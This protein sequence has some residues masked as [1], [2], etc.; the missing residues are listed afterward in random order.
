M[1]LKGS[2]HHDFRHAIDCF[3]D[4]VLPPGR[5]GGA[6]LTVYHGGKKVVDV[7]G[8]SVNRS[9]TPWQEDTL[10]C[11]FSTTKG[12]AS[13]LLHII[14]DKSDASYDDP[15]I[16]Y[17]PEYGQNNKAETT[18]RQAL[19]MEAGIHDIDNHGF[20]VDS[21]LH[22]PTALEKTAAATPRFVPGSDNAY[23]AINYGFL[24]GGIIEGITGKT[25]QT[26]LQE[27]LVDP[28][29]LKGLFIGV[30]EQE[31]AR[32]A[33]LLTACEE[34]GKVA[35]M[36]KFLPKW[37]Q[38]I[39]DLIVKLLHLSGRDT[40]HFKDAFA[41]DMIKT[42]ESDGEQKVDFNAEELRGACI[43]GANGVFTARS[44][45][46]VYAM[47]ANKGEWGGKRY[48]SENTVAEMGRVHNKRADKVIMVPIGWRLG[49][50]GAVSGTDY[51]RSSFGF[52]GLG[53]S[54]AWCNPELN[55][56]MALTVNSDIT[57][58]KVY[59]KMSKL[60][61]QVLTCALE[62]EGN[63]DAE[64]PRVMTATHP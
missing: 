24:I 12:I 53:G 32:C 51:A 43:P 8:G 44:L 50:H 52:A 15:I 19:T 16:K 31:K 36:F 7:W 58:P 63:L 20:D 1:Q 18:I 48:L 28:L 39:K 5:P 37:P 56:S 11:S 29:E 57:N 55:L 47:I 10:C 22:W 59:L 4:R 9:G 49:Y 21:F 35:V 25:F 26:V 54:I 30:P 38:L 3:I 40:Q 60:S 6:A 2:Y 42:H 17:W 33:D 41:L 23:H 46:K 45:A 64:A 62:R 27:E 34:D 13:T 61:R 14:M